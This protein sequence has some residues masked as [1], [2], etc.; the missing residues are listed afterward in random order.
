LPCEKNTVTITA[1]TKRETVAMNEISTRWNKTSEQNLQQNDTLHGITKNEVGT[2]RMFSR[3]G[4]A[5]MF[6]LM[7]QKKDLGPAKQ[8]ANGVCEHCNAPGGY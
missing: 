2:F 3:Q 6:P 4:N 7:I 1:K 8:L 5:D